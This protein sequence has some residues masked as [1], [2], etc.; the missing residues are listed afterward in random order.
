M[1]PVPIIRSCPEIPQTLKQQI[2][3]PDPG[4]PSVFRPSH[5]AASVSSGLLLPNPGT[6]RSTRHLPAIFACSSQHPSSLPPKPICIR[7]QQEAVPSTHPS[8]A[9]PGVAISDQRLTSHRSSDSYVWCVSPDPAKASVRSSPSVSVRPP[10]LARSS[11]E[12]HRQQVVCSH[13]PSASV[14]QHRPIGVVSRRT[15]VPE[16]RFSNQICPI[17]ADSV[18]VVGSRSP[19][20]SIRLSPSSPDLDPS[21]TG[22]GPDPAALASSIRCPSAAAHRS[23]PVDAPRRL[24]PLVI[25]QRDWPLAGD[26]NPPATVVDSIEDDL[27]AA[28]PLPVDVCLPPSAASRVRPHRRW[29]LLLL[30][31]EGGAP[32]YGAPAVYQTQ[33]TLR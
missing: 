6:L 18:F 29:S 9:S 15:S 4:T 11:A 23:L 30:G 20:A 10:L 16:T 24:R 8:L 3:C 14:R 31:K 26:P 32:Y 33:Y 2:V 21:T 5:H 25:R 28:S 7:H 12:I 1:V 27:P 17:R 13:V 19:S 22:T